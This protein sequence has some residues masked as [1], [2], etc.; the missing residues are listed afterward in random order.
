M[1]DITMVNSAVCDFIRKTL[2]AK[3]VK[4]IK[5]I[6]KGIQWEIEAEEYEESSFIKSLGLATKVMDKNFYTIILNENLEV[7]SYQRKEKW[8]QEV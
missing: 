6:K 8:E 2:N 1:T 3:D 5:A 7:E 4:V